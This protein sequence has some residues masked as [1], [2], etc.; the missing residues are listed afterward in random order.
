V[1]SFNKPSYCPMD[2]VHRQNIVWDRLHWGLVKGV[3][4]IWLHDGAHIN[5]PS[6]R[7]F[8]V[9]E[10]PMENQRGHRSPMVSL[11]CLVVRTPSVRVIDD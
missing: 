5:R 4:P 3:A 9:P 6:Q 7:I 8:T 10:I 11:I 2:Q 1:F